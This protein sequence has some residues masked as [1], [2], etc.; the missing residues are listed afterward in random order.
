MGPLS[1]W[2]LGQNAPVAPPVGGSAHA[3]YIGEFN[4]LDGKTPKK[5]LQPNLLSLVSFYA[6]TLAD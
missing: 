4:Y 5:Q 2:G 6:S 1:G 3:I